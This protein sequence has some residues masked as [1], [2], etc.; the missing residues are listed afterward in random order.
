MNGLGICWRLPSPSSVA[1]G[2]VSLKNKD[3]RGHFTLRD[4]VRKNGKNGVIAPGE[5][6]ERGKGC[7]D[8][9]NETFRRIP[10]GSQSRPVERASSRK[11]VLRG[12]GRPPLR[13]VD[14]QTESLD[15]EPRKFSRREPSLLTQAGAASTRCIGLACRSHR[16]PRPRRTVNRVAQEPGRSAVSRVFV[17]AP[18]SPN[19]KPPGSSPERLQAGRAKDQTRHGYR[20]ANAMSR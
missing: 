6:W 7:N 5:A 11:P 16:G 2:R 12:V 15:I 3:L 4:G 8:C 14:S 17:S 19:R 9:I 13:S 10:A 20:W 1:E 18:G